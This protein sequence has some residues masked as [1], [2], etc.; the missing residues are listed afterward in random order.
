MQCALWLLHSQNGLESNPGIARIGL[1]SSGVQLQSFSRNFNL[2][3][4]SQRNL[5]RMLACFSDSG[6]LSKR[7]RGIGQYLPLLFREQHGYV[8]LSDTRIE[9]SPRIG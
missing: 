2:A 7:G 1:G 6:L 9:C 5:S 4:V 8:R 3:F